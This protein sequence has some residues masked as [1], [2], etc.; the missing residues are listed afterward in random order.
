ML[1]LTRFIAPE[2][3]IHLYAR[4]CEPGLDAY[5]RSERLSLGGPERKNPQG[6]QGTWPEKDRKAHQSREGRPG[7]QTCIAQPLDHEHR[8]DPCKHECQRHNDARLRNTGQLGRSWNRQGSHPEEQ[9]A[10][11]KPPHYQDPGKEALPSS[12]VSW[13]E[14]GTP[15]WHGRRSQP[16]HLGRV[17]V[18]RLLGRGTD[19]SRR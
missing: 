1:A 6:E 15:E 3:L 5:L 9:G 16:S 17:V 12:P 10:E 11:E 13:R 8:L 19:R 18:E 2:R 4:G 14:P 7:W